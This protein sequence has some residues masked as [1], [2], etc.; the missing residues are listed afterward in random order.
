MNKLIKSFHSASLFFR[1]ALITF[2]CTLCVFIFT[3]SVTI[4]ISKNV[5][6][7]TF[8]SSNYKILNQVAQS[9][10]TLND[11]IANTLSIIE[12]STYFK[13]YLSNEDLTNKDTF[14]LIY[15]MDKQF[16]ILP[17]DVYSDI[18][19]YI[20][21]TN[22]E[23]FLKG[24]NYFYFDKEEML[25]S[26][27]TK[28]AVKSSDKLMYEYTT[29]TNVHT[30]VSTNTITGVKVLKDKE[31]K[32]IYGYVY[33]I[34]K[35][36][37]FKK[38]YMPFMGASN[39]IAII[40]KNGQVVS[41]SI[42]NIIGKNDNSLLKIASHM[43]Q[44]NITI[45]NTKYNNKN[46]SILKTYLPYYN[47]NIIGI[48]DRN[49]IINEVF[50]TS[51][52][53][54]FNIIILILFLFITFFII[55][56]TTKPLSILAY[57]MSQVSDGKFNNY[58]KTEGSSEVRKLTEAYNYMLDG[59]NKYMQDLV[60]LE[61]EKRKSEIHALQMQINPHFMYNT[62]SSIKWLIWQ[63]DKDK[64]VKTIDAFIS[65]LRNT[66]S[67]KNEMILIFE[68]VTNLKNYVLI[69]HI[70]YGDKITV[71]YFVQEECN[72]YMIPKLI[73]QPFI[74]NAFFHAFTDRE[75][76][77]ISVFIN[78]K[79]NNIVCEIIDNGIG[80]S[81][82]NMDDIFKSSELKEHFTSIGIN[83]VNDRIKLLYGDEYGVTIQSELNFGT[84]VK[85]TI[86]AKKP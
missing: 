74:E 47:F 34:I 57:K 21:G 49:L 18:T 9:F 71:N 56:R 51:D 75:S 76:G 38:Y 2:I 50:N 24:H 80:I 55:R 73:L 26:H 46:K 30:K 78:L 31:S 62:L 68:E 67:N 14:S 70:R 69:N 48:I 20:V 81:N 39:D 79:D 77:L 82:N 36:D 8:G 23:T 5:L 1:V 28:R 43:D 22:G 54:F 66:I 17:E 12:N 19:V 4:N 53:Y 6:I 35:E 37:D 29:Y 44:N 11:N 25:N 83:N 10:L 16:D 84:S 59:I 85:I 86:P 7:K 40:S 27:I 41:S 64:S 52:I 65:L 58:I 32:L 13:T 45:Y 33:I 15:N 60:E 72:N 3:T 61:K 42:D 63:N